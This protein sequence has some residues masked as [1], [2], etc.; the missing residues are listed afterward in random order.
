MSLSSSYNIYWY[1]VPMRI[2]I[3]LINVLRH[4]EVHD[5]KLQTLRTITSY[6][7]LVYISSANFKSYTEAKSNIRNEMYFFLLYIYSPGTK[8]RILNKLT[9]FVLLEKKPLSC[10]SLFLHTFS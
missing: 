7:Y 4:A 1:L 5:E 9:S 10:C 6:I 2:E 8:K 3:S